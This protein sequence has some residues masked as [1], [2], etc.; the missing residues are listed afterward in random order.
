MLEVETSRLDLVDPWG[1]VQVVWGWEE[2]EVL[3]R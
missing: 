2:G 1:L 3:R